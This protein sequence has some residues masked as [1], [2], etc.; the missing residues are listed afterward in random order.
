MMRMVRSFMYKHPRRDRGLA[1]VMAILAPIALLLMVALVPIHVGSRAAVAAVGPLAV[2]GTIYSSSGAIVAGASVVVTILDGTNVRV[3][4]PTTSDINGFY[5]VSVDPS[6]WSTGNTILVG[7]TKGSDFGE[8]STVADEGTPFATIDVHLGISTI[9]ELGGPATVA[10][11]VTA[12]G[13]LVVFFAR[14]R[15]SSSP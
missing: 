13:M 14:R 11:T 1:K 12:I 5:A 3:V 2:D 9:P 15:G 8:N 6:F 4:M 7:A 10:L